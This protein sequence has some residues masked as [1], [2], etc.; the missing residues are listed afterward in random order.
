MQVFHCLPIFLSVV[1]TLPLK[2]GCFEFRSIDVTLFLKLL[3]L[4]QL[5]QDPDSLARLYM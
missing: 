3:C 2:N 1:F 4:F 5:A